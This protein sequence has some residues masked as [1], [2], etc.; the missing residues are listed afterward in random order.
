MLATA[1]YS[2]LQSVGGGL[3]GAIIVTVVVVGVV[4]LLK[5]LFRHI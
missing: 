5:A 4:V 2:T 1:H 3:I